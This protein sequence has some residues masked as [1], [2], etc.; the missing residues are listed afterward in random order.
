MSTALPT[1]AITP[2]EPAGIGPDLLVQLAQLP[3]HAQLVAFANADLLAD[4]AKRLSLPLELT[5]FNTDCRQASTGQG[6]LSIVESDLAVIPQPGQGTAASASY[7][8]NTLD[9]AIEHAKRQQVDALVTGPINKHLINT[10]T[11]T[12]QHF[13]GHTE[14]LAQQTATPR[15]VMM[16]AVENPP[17]LPQPLRVALATT[18]LPLRDVPAAITYETIEQTLIILHQALIEQF[19]IAQPRILICGLNPHAG[20]QGD[21][22][23]EEIDVIQPC[24][25]ALRT[26]GLDLSDA[27]PA[28]TLF[29]SHHL[30]QADAVLA[31]YH[32][33]GLPVLK[34]HGF[35]E[36]VNITLG[37]PF[38]RTSVDH[39]TAFDLAGTGRANIG[40]LQAAIACA[41]NLSAKRHEH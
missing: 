2:G 6:K 4:R 36:S 9:Q 19:S 38:I 33:Q 30:N 39:G 27:M 23:S 26:Q 7:V 13:T 40:S 32:D 17:H 28:D 20:E 1:I 24:I 10:G 37:L 12:T 29:T 14:Y 8:I 18:H 22:G 16:L 15:V 5:S 35:G 41:I 31:M 3:H 11:S 21:L 25:E 34:S